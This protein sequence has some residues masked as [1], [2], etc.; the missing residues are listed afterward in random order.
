MAFS[1][2]QVAVL[3]HTL[4]TPTPVRRVPLEGDVIEAASE[5]AADVPSFKFSDSQ[6]QPQVGQPA[7]SA[8]SP[9]EQTGA[10]LPIASVAMKEGAADKPSAPVQPRAAAEQ[11]QLRRPETRRGLLQDMHEVLRLAWEV[12]SAFTCICLGFT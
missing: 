9:K 10:G 3:Q 2:M 1:D 12:S 7:A 6:K 8:A 4:G 5:A 11:P